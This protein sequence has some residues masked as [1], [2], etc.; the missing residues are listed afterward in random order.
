MQNLPA[1]FPLPDDEWYTYDRSPRP[2]V[3]VLATVDEASYDPASDIRM[4]DHP[5]VWVN[6]AKTARNVYIQMGHSPKLLDCPAFTTLF[7][8]AIRW[9]LH[10]E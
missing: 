6:E 9:T 7:S 3:H 4:G 5:V 10:K 1:T 2:Q 8:N